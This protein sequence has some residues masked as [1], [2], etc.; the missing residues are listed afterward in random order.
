MKWMA[1]VA[2]GILVEGQ[3]LFKCWM[4]SNSALGTTP[5]ILYYIIILPEG[6]AHSSIC[7]L[8]QAW[9]HQLLR[10]HAIRLEYFIKRVGIDATGTYWRAMHYQLE[11]WKWNVMATPHIVKQASPRQKET[12]RWANRIQTKHNAKNGRCKERQGSHFVL[13][14]LRCHTQLI[15]HSAS[16]FVPN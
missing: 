12:K 16:Y 15:L 11:H 6:K 5:I 8:K 10:L 3:Q 7:S 1:V 13:L 4:W 2:S 14:L 9:W